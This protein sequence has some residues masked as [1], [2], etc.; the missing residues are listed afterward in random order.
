MQARRSHLAVAAEAWLSL[1]RVRQAEGVADA[2]LAAVEKA[3][4]LCREFEAPVSPLRTEAE[5]TLLRLRGP[6]PPP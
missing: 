3:V 4:A 2:A 1:A 5:S 6:E